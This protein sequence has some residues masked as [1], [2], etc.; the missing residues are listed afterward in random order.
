MY[1]SRRSNALGSEEELPYPSKC[2]TTRALA[3]CWMR[4]WQV[5][6]TV[7]D[8]FTSRIKLSYGKK[9][10]LQAS[11]SR[12]KTQ[13]MTIRKQWD[14]EKANDV[15]FGEVY[16][17]KSRDHAA[18]AQGAKDEL[19]DTLNRNAKR[20]YS[21]LE[22]AINS[23]CSTRTIE[24]WFKSHA[25]FTSYSQNVR[26]L[27]SEG[28]RL[29]QVKFSQH[30]RNRWGLVE[31]T[32]ILWTMR[33]ITP[34]PYLYLSSSSNCTPTSSDEKWFYGLV[35]RTFAKACESLGITKQTFSCQHKSHINKVTLTLTLT[36]T[37]TVTLSLTLTLYQTR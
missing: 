21:S 17:K 32:K 28:N 4:E 7:Q 25:D 37:L 23:W 2:L 29:K 12:I 11:R 35:A 31:G 22:K 26:P 33:Y 8:I 15:K 14:F 18:R 3:F 16:E 9:N 34:Y 19:V 27:L 30:V 6:F 5:A 10:N 1:P 13:R 20:S 36:L 24:R